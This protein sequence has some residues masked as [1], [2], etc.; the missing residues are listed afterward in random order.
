MAK[1]FNKPK[2]TKKQ[3][4]VAAEPQPRKKPRV[5]EPFFHEDYPLAWRFSACDKGGPWAWTNLNPADKY[6][7][8]V[9]KLHS[10][11]TMTETVMRQGGSHPVALDNIAGDAVQR[12]REIQQDDLDELMSFRLTGTNRVW[13]VRDRNIMR[14]LWWDPDHQVSPA[15]KKHT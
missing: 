12:L 6:K 2:K 5:G 8:V 4:K 3:P 11:E 1:K 10:F 7:E 9:E 14:V 13:C 15:K